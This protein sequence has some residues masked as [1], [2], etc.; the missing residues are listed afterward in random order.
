MFDQIIARLTRMVQFDHTVYREIAQDDDATIQAAA[1]IVVVAFLSAIGSAIAARSVLSFFLTL[2]VS[3]PLGWLIWTGLVYLVGAKLFNG[4]GTFMG[5]LRVLGYTMAPSVL[6]ILA[7]IPCLGWIAA[8][9]GAVL[10]LV[11][12]FFAIRETMELT[13]EKAVL[14]I[15]IG[16]VLRL[17]I[18]LIGI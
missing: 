10:S 1:I 2:I 14:T 13:T 12:G 17:V 16:W 15:V 18:G 11:L 5:M 8:L 9:V 4:Q 7:V 3:V 6:G